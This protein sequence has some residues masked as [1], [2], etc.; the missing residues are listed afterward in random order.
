MAGFE[1]IKRMFGDHG[2]RRAAPRSGEPKEACILVVDDSPTIRAVL[3]KMLAQNRHVVLKAADGESALEIARTERPDLVFLDIVMPGMSGFA[4]LRALRHDLLT[5]DIPI[6]MISGNLQATEQFYVQRF[7]A[8]DFM[9]KPFGR[10]EVFAR[11]DNLTRS[12]R[13]VV[14]QR[15]ETERIP[16]EPEPSAAEHAAIPDIA[17]PDPHDMVMPPAGQD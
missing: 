3:G 14:R 11:I 12:G 8:D 15:A 16:A 10:S 2:E 6:V 1:L 13:L 4:V 7:G 17:M 9:K 5:R